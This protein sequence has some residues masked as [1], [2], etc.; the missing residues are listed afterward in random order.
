MIITVQQ[1]PEEKII[2]MFK[3]YINKSNSQQT[4]EIFEIQSEKKKKK[5]IRGTILEGEYIRKEGTIH[6]IFCQQGGVVF[7]YEVLIKSSSIGM[8]DLLFLQRKDSRNLATN[9]VK[10]EN[11]LRA[12]SV[13]IFFFKKVKEFGEDI[14]NLQLKSV[15]M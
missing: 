9:I 11:D 4:S 14:K 7:E 3:K 12:E 8:N 15:I 5:E 6:F 10:N 2:K 1:L 13:K